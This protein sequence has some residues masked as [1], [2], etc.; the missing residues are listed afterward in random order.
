MKFLERF[1]EKW[2]RFLQL[3][4]ISAPK[5]NTAASIALHLFPGAI[6]LAVSYAFIP[7][8]LQAHLPVELAGHIDTV[9]DMLP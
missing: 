6:T 2:K 5:H 9:I 7:V 1:L 3:E 8:M 4:P